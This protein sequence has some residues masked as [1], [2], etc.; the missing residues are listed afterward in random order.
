LLTVTEKAVS[1]V[2]F[3]KLVITQVIYNLGTHLE[4]L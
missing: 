1:L 2:K 3:I 4:H